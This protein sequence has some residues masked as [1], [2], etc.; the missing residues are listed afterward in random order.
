MVTLDCPT[1]SFTLRYTTDINF[2]T[3]SKDFRGHS[4]TNLQFC[5]LG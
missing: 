5:K 2:L 3:G 4:S 1:K